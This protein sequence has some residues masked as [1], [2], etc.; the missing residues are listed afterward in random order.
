MLLN[1]YAEAHARPNL[2]RLWV[3]G[4]RMRPRMPCKR[5]ALN[6]SLGPRSR[7]SRRATPR[8]GIDVDPDPEKIGA[9]DYFAA[10][11]WGKQNEL[12]QV[13][14]SQL[15]IYLYEI[16]LWRSV[17]QQQVSLTKHQSPISAEQKA[18]SALHG[19][20]DWLQSLSAPS[21]SPLQ[22]GRAVVWRT[23]HQYIALHAERIGCSMVGGVIYSL[24]PT[25]SKTHCQP[26]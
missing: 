12:I 18:A 19:L 3:S 8:A 24:R 17:N 25:N 23:C 5:T 26:H 4:V 11:S 20:K 14:H 21:N 22:D 9:V 7:R 2:A 15:L 16:L 10:H 13:H 1:T 6:P